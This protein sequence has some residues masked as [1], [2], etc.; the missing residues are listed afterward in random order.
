MADL[1][2][3]NAHTKAGPASR[4][5]Q[6]QRREHSPG[7]VTRAGRTALSKRTFTSQLRHCTL[8]ATHYKLRTIYFA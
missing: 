2:A 4:I 1:R 5:V 3:I 7:S 8:R 6:L